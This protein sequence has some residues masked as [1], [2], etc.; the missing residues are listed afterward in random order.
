MRKVLLLV[1]LGWIALGFLFEEP[2]CEIDNNDRAQLQALLGAIG[3][4]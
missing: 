2:E 3:D 4:E 1:V